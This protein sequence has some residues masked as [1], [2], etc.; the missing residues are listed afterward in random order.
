MAG[1]A[2][3][4]AASPRR[5]STTMGD[6]A[7]AAMTSAAFGGDPWPFPG[8][9]AAAAVSS[10]GAEASRR[11]HARIWALQ[12]LLRRSK[13]HVGWAGLTVTAFNRLDGSSLQADAGRCS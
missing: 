12:C 10:H 3:R 7:R 6:D 2:V 13:P 1:A 9:A 8:A 4:Q 11:R 5:P